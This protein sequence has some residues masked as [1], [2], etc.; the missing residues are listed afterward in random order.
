MSLE[1]QDSD[2][3]QKETDEIIEAAIG[4]IGV[5][6]NDSSFNVE[7]YNGEYKAIGEYLVTLKKDETMMNEYF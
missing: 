7:D 1:D 3:D 6:E 4:A 2:Y 5:E